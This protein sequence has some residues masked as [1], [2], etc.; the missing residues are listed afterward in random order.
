MNLN[1]YICYYLHIYTQFCFIWNHFSKNAF[2]KTHLKPFW[3]KRQIFI[4]S[5]INLNLVMLAFQLY[6]NKDLLNNNLS[7]KFVK[8]S[9]CQFVYLYI[10]CIFFGNFFYCLLYKKMILSSPTEKMLYKSIELF[11]RL[12]F[13]ELFICYRIIKIF[14]I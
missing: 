9:V 13:V 6:G 4:S 8:L 12:K 1:Y 7:T 10:C 11:L 3:N 14:S 2:R 5:Y